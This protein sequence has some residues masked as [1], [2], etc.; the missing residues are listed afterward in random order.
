MRGM[1]HSTLARIAR[2]QDDNL[3]RFDA[4]P[5]LMELKTN[6]S[7][8]G[9]AR[10]SRAAP[11]SAAPPS[12]GLHPPAHA[13]WTGYGL[14]PDQRPWPPTE[15]SSAATTGPRPVTYIDPRHF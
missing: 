6:A 3:R 10:S 12:A 15:G 11:S 4:L 1:C 14:P 2:R 7:A 13:Y 8:A 9:G 5:E